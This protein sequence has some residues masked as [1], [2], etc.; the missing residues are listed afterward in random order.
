MS[1]GGVSAR[2]PDTN[3]WQD[4]A[5]NSPSE[6]FAA[7]GDLEEAIEILASD[8]VDPDKM[9]NN[10]GELSVGHGVPGSTGETHRPQPPKVAPRPAIKPGEDLDHYYKRIGSVDPVRVMEA[11]IQRLCNEADRK[12]EAWLDD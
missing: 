8:Y 1:I 4:L 9:W 6:R 3:D 12:S 11:Q 10:F 5:M 7:M 2:H